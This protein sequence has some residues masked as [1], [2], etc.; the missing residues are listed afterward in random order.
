ME[1]IS[2]GK[3]VELA[4]KIFLVEKDG[5]L[6]TGEARRP[7]WQVAWDNEGNGEILSLNLR[8]QGSKHGTYGPQ[9]AGKHALCVRGRLLRRG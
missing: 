7:G 3:F 5:H 2:N 9:A 6:L 4:Y 8:A 1:T